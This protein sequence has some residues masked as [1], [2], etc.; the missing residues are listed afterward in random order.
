VVVDDVADLESPLKRD[1]GVG[2]AVFAAGFVAAVFLEFAP[3]SYTHRRARERDARS[4]NDINFV[5]D[6]WS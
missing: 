1:E 4:G 3:L 5:I 2:A 6:Y